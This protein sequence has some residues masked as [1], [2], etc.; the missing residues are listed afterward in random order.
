MLEYCDWAAFLG[1]DLILAK[2]P[3]NG[4]VIFKPGRKV[5][6]STKTDS[7]DEYLPIRVFPFQQGALNRL[8]TMAVFGKH[9]IAG[10]SDGDILLIDMTGSK[11]P[12]KVDA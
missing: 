4:A 2:S 10:N 6:S 8:N 3:V 11:P 1:R 7:Q 9:L 5:K 12:A